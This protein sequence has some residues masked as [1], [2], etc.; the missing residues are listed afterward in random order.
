MKNIYCTGVTPFLNLCASGILSKNNKITYL[1]KIEKKGSAQAKIESKDMRLKEKFV[2]DIACFFGY[3]VNFQIFE[4][5][6]IND[7]DIISGNLLRYLLPFLRGQKINIFPEGASCLNSIKRKSIKRKIYARSSYIF[8]SFFVGSYKINK[9]W[10]L[11][12]RD[13]NNKY[14]LKNC[15]LLPEKKL[16]SNIKKCSNFMLNKYPELNLCKDKKIIFHPINQYLDKALYK[17]WIENHK[18][19]IGNKKLILKAHENDYRDYSNVF[20]NFNT[21][22]VPKKF[23][24][25]PAELILDNFESYYLGYYSSI[26]LH[27]KRKNINFIIPPDKKLIKISENEFDGLKHLMKL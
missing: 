23:I 14:I 4:K 20:K 21:F 18:E 7:G 8:K 3:T 2:T 24:T 10:I 25:L 22:F 19:F 12:N 6:I 5:P 17:S 15:K 9:R 16:F 27:F 1:K 13:R 11:P 26:M